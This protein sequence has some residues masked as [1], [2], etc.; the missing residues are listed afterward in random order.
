MTAEDLLQTFSVILA[1]T[2]IAFIFSGTGWSQYTPATED[3][4]LT[5]L[6]LK[7]LMV[8]F[9]SIALV[10]SMVSMYLYDLHGEKLQKM[11]EELAKHPELR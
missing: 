1:I 5:I 11:R 4:E 3:P 8:V 2:T 6:G 10:G 7:L 9:P